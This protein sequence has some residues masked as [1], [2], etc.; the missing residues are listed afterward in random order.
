MPTVFRERG[1]R[2]Y[3]YEAD[4][5]E[6]MHVHVAKSSKLA[7]FWIEPIGVAVTEGFKN[8]ELNEIERII[9]ERYDEIVIAWRHEQAKRHNR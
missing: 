3:F 6:P 1:Y 8:H 4:F 2:F 9:N 7:K 5:D